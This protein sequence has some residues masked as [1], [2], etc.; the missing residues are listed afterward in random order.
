MYKKA[1]LSVF[2]MLT[3]T[4]FKPRVLCEI[5]NMFIYTILGMRLKHM[6]FVTGWFYHSTAATLFSFLLFKNL[7]I[8]LSTD[9]LF[10]YNR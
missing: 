3:K 6:A 2:D 9:T 10:V 4:L 8:I 1:R 7:L 5:F